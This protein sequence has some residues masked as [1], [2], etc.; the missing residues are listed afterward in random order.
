MIG[1]NDDANHSATTPASIGR[2]I[3]PAAWRAENAFLLAAIGT[4]VAPHLV[5]VPGAPLDWNYLIRAAHLHGVSPLLHAATESDGS[6]PEAARDALRTSWW[7]T[8]FRNRMLVGELKEILAAAHARQ[9]PIMPL[10]GALLAPRYYSTPALRPMSDIDLLVR[11]HDLHAARDLFSAQ[12]YP[13]VAPAVGPVTGQHPHPDHQEYV[14]VRYRHGEPVMVELRAEPLDPVGMGF[15]T[16]DSTLERRLRRNVA[17][18]WERSHP[19]C[20]DGIPFLH[21]APEDLLLHIASHLTTRHTNFRLLWL[22]DLC[23]VI[24][25]HEQSIDWPHLMETARA[26]RVQVPVLAALEAAHTLLGAPVPVRRL[27]RSCLRTFAVI[28]RA[29]HRLFTRQARALPTADLGT[30]PMIPAWLIPVS[31]LR[32]HGFRARFRAVWALIAPD[33]AYMAQWTAE[34]VSGNASYRRALLLRTLLGMLRMGTLA[35]ARVRPPRLSR[36]IQRF[37]IRTADLLHLSLVPPDRG[38]ATPQR[39]L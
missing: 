27:Q 19:D 11:P 37:A 28:E 13:A 31:L 5:P 21:I 39:W 24:A 16:L 2:M 20:L 36:A 18:I 30:V 4:S 7:T 15:L 35:S 8:H 9:I 25:Q 22:H 32:L 1:G 6:I 23:T 3:P 14:F 10:K 34:T 38:E 33:R 17:G 26:V 12:G 29:E